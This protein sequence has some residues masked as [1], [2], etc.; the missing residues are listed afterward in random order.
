MSANLKSRTPLLG[1]DVWHGKDMEKRTDWI[2]V[3]E[4]EEIADLQRAISVV[5]AAGTDMYAV[6][7]GK[8]P[9]PVL[10]RRFA[11]ISHA[12]EYGCGVANIRGIPTDT[13][14][15]EDLRWVLWGI[16]AHLGTAVSQNKAGEFFAEVKD[17]GEQLGRPNSR[18]YRTASSLR[19]HTDRCDVVAL[20][21]ARQCKQGGESRIVSTPAI[22]NAMLERR[23]D[24]LEE[25]FGEFHHSRQNEEVAGQL[26]FYV[27]PIFGVHKGRF[28]SQYSRSYV[29]SAQRFHAAP[30]LSAGQEEA[31]DLLASL[32]EELCL[33][34]RMEP[35][36]IQLLNNH[37]TYHSRTAIVDFDEPEMKRLVYRLWLSTPESRELPKGY[38]VLWGPTAA[39]ALRGGV[40]PA[41]GLRTVGEWRSLAGQTA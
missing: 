36:D 27:N 8:F 3:L 9:L 4:R 34:T 16:G 13:F 12:L 10:S 6:T 14:S 38:E 5:R 37:V 18:G 41:N 15:M 28:S 7:A 11:A 26:P 2:H 32:A 33:Q 40:P 23:P 39:G 17:Y 19:F 1:P 21:C 25:L 35:G 24:L 30:R 22:H 20:L 29:E 31:L